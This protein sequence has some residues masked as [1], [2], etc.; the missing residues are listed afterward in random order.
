MQG[1]LTQNLAAPAPAAEDN[2]AVSTVISAARRRLAEQ[3]PYAYYFRHV[4]LEYAAG[5]LTLTGRLPSFYMKQV[6]QSLL[7]NLEG[8]KLIDNRVDVVSA[9]GLSSVRPR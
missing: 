5:V 6:L 3:C 1:S 4:G 8:V 7:R 2:A 9:T